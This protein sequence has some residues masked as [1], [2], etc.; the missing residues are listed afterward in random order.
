M[1]KNLRMSIHAITESYGM[2][3]LLRIMKLNTVLLLITAFQVFAN[4]VYSQHTELTLKLG[5][6]SVGQVLTEIENQSEFYFLFNQKLVDTERRVNVQLSNKK[7]GEVLDYVFNGTT[8]DYVVMDRQIVL[9]PKEYLAEVKSTM[10]PRTIT[11]T[12]LDEN[13]DPLAGANILI[14]GTTTGVI[15]D[16]NGNYSIQ[17]DAGAT[18]VISFIGYTPQEILVGN[19]TTID[20]QLELSTVGLEEVVTIGYGTVRKSDLTGSVGSVAGDELNKGAISSVEQALQ[21]KTPG[22]MIRQT[23]AEPGG[24][25][26]VRI[27]GSGSIT[28]GNEPLYVI[29]GVPVTTSNITGS[30]T[31]Y[32][33]LQVRSSALGSLNSNDIESVEVLKDAS[34]TAIYGSRGANGVV[35]ITTKSG[36]S[37]KAVVNYN[38]YGGVQT[39][40]KLIDLLSTQEYID[41]LNYIREQLGEAPE[42]TPAEISAIGAGTDWQDY[43][44]QT[45]VIQEH[46]LSISGGTPTSKYYISGNYFDQEGIVKNT[47][48]KKYIFRSNLEQTIKEKLTI[49]MHL[50]ASLINSDNSLESLNEN[51]DSGPV[52]S[53]LGYDPTIPIK[54]ADGEY[55]TS[56]DLTLTHPARILNGMSSKSARTR[57]FGDITGSYEIIDG[58]RAKVLVGVDRN[59]VRTDA[60]SNRLTIRG[61]AQDG[62]ANVN[63]VERTHLLT[64]GTLSYIK[65]INESN[66]I[67]AVA[68]VTYENVIDRNFRAGSESF[69]SDAFLTNNLGAGDPTL[70]SV[71]SN[72]SEYTLLSYLGRVIYSLYDKYMITVSYRIDGSSRFGVDNKYGYFPSV[73]LGWRL[74]D[75]VFIPD[76][77]SQLKLRAS[78]GVTGNQDIG[79]YNSL[80]TLSPG[81]VWLGDRAQPIVGPARKPNPD[82]KWEETTQYNV[83][84]DYGFMNN[85]IQGSIDYYYK[86][87][88]DLLLDLPLPVSSGYSS[89]LTNLGGMKNSG[90]EF[91]V[92]ATIVSRTDLSWNVAFNISTQKNEVTDIG[93]LPSIS[94]GNSKLTG[95]TTITRVGDPLN[96]YY[97]FNV[98]GF[99]ESQ[100]QIDD[101]AQPGA[102]LGFPIIEDVDGDGSITPDDRIILGSQ[103]ADFS[104]GL[105]SVLSYKNFTL[106]LF[107]QGEHGAD[108]LNVNTVQGMYP[109]NFRRNRYAPLLLDQWKPENTDAAWPTA[110]NPYRYESYKVNNLV[111]EDASYL[112]LKTVTLSYTFP[113]INLNMFESIRVYVRGQNLLTITDYSGFNPETNMFGSGSTS[114]LDWNAYPVARVMMIGLDVTF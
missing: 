95:N 39:P 73:A 100:G 45:G 50:N 6:S 114:R 30:G 88:K 59:V 112:R 110:V 10:Q 17:A 29:D 19:Q 90:F 40:E 23:S 84:I 76:L 66:R 7:I 5:E 3:K 2:A 81:T 51:E 80:M 22:V 13:G 15:T 63:E 43:V 67:N 105:S 87:T 46:N 83:G 61:G 71:N 9:S 91:A 65:D 41:G 96:S 38:G 48:I 24:E 106:D 98:I 58:L 99:F 53:A 54:T 27:R 26:S 12:V 101:S 33:A 1:K 20:V 86:D 56:F 21:G 70:A 28:A 16:P 8:T 109:A 69:P 34:A 108:L 75:E 79:N 31:S 107:I 92:D 103:F 113:N 68:G 62:I 32:D 60:Y 94:M 97:G 36:T 77:F 57:L 55:A 49:G 25:L 37:G 102:D 82:L 74:S 11:G 111:I 42:F 47:G 35:L 104:Y 18:L 44:T 85:R 14:K 64:E 93:G 4:G 89:I 72:K 78:W 52:N